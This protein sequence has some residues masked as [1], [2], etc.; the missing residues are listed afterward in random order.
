M[1]GGHALKPRRDEN[2]SERAILLTVILGT[3]LVPL[4]STMIAVALPRVIA[5][6]HS[7]LSAA[8]WLVTGYLIAMASLQPVAGRL[9]DRIG[10]RPF[11]LGGLALFAVASLAAAV[12]PDLPLLIFFRILQAVAGALVFPNGIALL[13]EH[14]PPAKL[15]GRLG[16]VGAA[17][18]LAAAAGPLVGGL[19]LALG[20]WRTIFLLNLP[21]LVV[22]L[23]LGWRTIPR[24]HGEH[25]SERFD[26]G[27]AV[28]LSA[29]LVAGAWVLINGLG[30]V[31]GAVALAVACA[32]AP[33][34]FGQELR[35]PKPLLQ[36]RLFAHAPFLAANGGV[37]LSNLAM[38]V[39]LFALPLL[40]ARRGDW[41]SARIG[42]ALAA[43]SLATFL[44]SPFGGRLAERLGARTPG[45]VGLTLLTVSLVPLALAPATISRAALVATLIGAGVGLGLS[46]AP[47]Q[48]AALESVEV[49]AAGIASGIFSTSRYL[50]SITGTALLAGPLA[51]AARGFGGF[52]ALFATL[53]A[54]A[55]GAAL[56]ALAL[57]GRG[58]RAPGPS[59]V[60]VRV[61]SSDP[62]P[63]SRHRLDG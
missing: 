62:G 45:V 19:L 13:R 16:L 46:S 56:L 1:P 2:P 17:L 39:T 33:L 35:H 7:S 25:R 4:N 34:L 37:A 40:L 28:W 57:P 44:F 54:A 27:G 50:G 29:L 58:H 32:A 10:R 61:S 21:L 59:A 49:S 30:D 12:A 22:P 15:A 31:G 52:G 26:A 47:L 24:R 20:G 36:P 51:P 55:A 38:Y 41:T 18:P 8:G 5:D 63:G 60:A 6:F 42:L 11:V 48:A 43:L 23:A 53:A 14:A 3:M 9:G